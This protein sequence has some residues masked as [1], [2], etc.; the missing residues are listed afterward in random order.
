MHNA[1]IGVMLL[2]AVGASAVGQNSSHGV[3]RKQYWEETESETLW[4][5]Q[6]A[7]CDYGC[8]VMLADEMVGHGTHSPSPNHGFLIALPDAGR[9]RDASLD[10]EQLIWVD[11]EYNVTEAHALRN[12]A[13][14]YLDLAGR[15]KHSLK[16]IVRRDSRLNGR[17]AVQFKLE[18]DGSKG[19]VVEEEIVAL[20]AG[21]VYEVGL[22]TT[23][24]NYAADYERFNRV[25]SGFRFWRIHYC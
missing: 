2:L 22:R 6:Y 18:Y 10:D 23:P 20:R 24:G 12:V 17:P 19:K 15:D 25:I 8:Y 21:I 1:I 13:D 9:I 11:A 14:Y 3:T 4:R 7:N 16:V 5:R